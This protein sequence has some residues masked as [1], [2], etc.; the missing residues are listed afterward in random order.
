MKLKMFAV[1]MDSKEK[2]ILR[3]KFNQR[4][5]SILRSMD[6]FALMCLAGLA[7]AKPAQSWAESA[8]DRTDDKS[9]I[10][11]LSDPSQDIKFM[12]Q[13]TGVSPGKKEGLPSITVNP[14]WLG[15]AMDGFGFSLTGGSALHL[16]KMSVEDRMALLIELFDHSENNIGVSYLRVS[17]GA[18]DLDASVFSYCDLPEGQTDVDMAHF[19]LDEDRKHLVPVLKEILQINPDIKIMASP[20][21]PPVWMKTNQSSIG[22]SLKPIYYIIAHASKFVRPGSR[23]IGSTTTATLPNVA[24]KTVDDRIVI[25]VLNDS[26][27]EK[28]FNIIVGEEAIHSSLSAGAVGTYVW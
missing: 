22:G 5:A 26:Q 17:I 20:W 1:N 6:M 4:K 14:R 15:Q 9:V 21:S 27:S 23:R 16:H 11:W 18:S 19:T 2:T 24:F 10:L 7:C 3:L 8:S 28:A 13:S 12:E 25:I